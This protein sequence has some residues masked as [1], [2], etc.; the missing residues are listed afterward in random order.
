MVA[1]KRPI[2]VFVYMQ[3]LIT[4]KNKPGNSVYTLCKN[5]YLPTYPLTFLKIWFYTWPSVIYVGWPWCNVGQH[6]IV[7]PQLLPT[8]R[9]RLPM[10]MVE[11]MLLVWAVTSLARA[12]CCAAKDLLFRLKYTNSIRGFI[13]VGL[14]IVSL[15]III[16]GYRDFLCKSWLSLG[17]NG[18]QIDHITIEDL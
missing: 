4:L 7:L 8:C 9:A 14:F 12:L 6:A 2:D 5:W 10:A 1:C 18:I 15:S 16:T 17:T 3:L 13:C 11:C